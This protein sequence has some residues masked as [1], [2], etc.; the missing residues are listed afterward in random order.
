MPGLNSLPITPLK[1]SR[2]NQKRPSMLETLNQEPGSSFLRNSNDKI[3]PFK[4]QAQSIIKACLKQS[5]ENAH[6]FRDVDH[7][8][9]TLHRKKQTFD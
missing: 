9:F 3:D 2:A 1:S 7:K 6:D 5:E 4:N 8:F